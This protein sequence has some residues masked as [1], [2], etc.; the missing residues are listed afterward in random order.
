MAVLQISGQVIV[1]TAGSA[2][3]FT[4]TAGMI[5]PGLFLVK[6]LPANTGVCYVGN[7]GASDVT[8]SNGFPLSAGDVVPETVT[9]IYN[10]IVDST[11]SGEG[12]GWLRVGGAV[13]GIDSP[14]I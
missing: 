14:A 1:S 10:L 11:V 12:V 6:G 4:T 2:V 8:S 7:D 3:H 9:D 13:V 5:E